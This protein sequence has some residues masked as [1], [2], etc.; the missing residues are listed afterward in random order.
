MSGIKFSRRTRT[1]KWKASSSLTSGALLLLMTI[2]LY[3]PNV[4]RPS[5]RPGA[6]QHCFDFPRPGDG[7][8]AV[9]L[10]L[11]TGDDA[12]HHLLRLLNDVAA[13]RQPLL[14]QPV[15]CLPPQLLV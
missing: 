5:L 7:V 8:L 15:L 2:C 13:H 6:V 4:Q 3:Q 1:M 12:V 9:V 11:V 14:P 10:F